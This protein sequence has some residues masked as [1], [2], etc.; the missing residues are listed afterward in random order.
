MGFLQSTY[1]K[2]KVMADTK[3]VTYDIPNHRRGETFDGVL[4]QSL[5]V[6]GNLIDL[7]GYI[8]EADFR[9]NKN[10]IKQQRWSNNG[11]N[12]KIE[13]LLPTSDGNFRFKDNFVVDLP[14]AKYFYDIRFIAPTNKVEYYVQ[15]TFQVEEN[16]TREG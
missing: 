10:G 13:V 2:H 6:N 3:I 7:N 14:P 1:V 15:G 12:P 4:F 11:V 9:Q 16:V 8:I 5:T